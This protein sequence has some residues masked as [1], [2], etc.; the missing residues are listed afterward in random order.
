[1]HATQSNDETYYIPLL[2]SLQQLLNYEFILSEV[3]SY[4]TNLSPLLII[5]Y[6][7]MLFSIYNI[8]YKFNPF[9]PRLAKTT[10]SIILLCL[11]PDDFTHPGRSSGW[12]RAK[13]FFLFNSLQLSTFLF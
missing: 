10:P 13:M 7:C 1:M 8:S 6:T 9:P 11:T 4:P 3:W 2:D 5:D 12:E